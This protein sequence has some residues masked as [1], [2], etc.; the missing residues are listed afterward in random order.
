MKRIWKAELLLLMVTMIWGGTF[1]I[2]KSVLEDTPPFL[3][4]VYR[5]GIA[6][7]ISAIIWRKFLKGFAKVDIVQGTILGLLYGIGFLLQAFGLTLTSASKSGFVTG[8][9]VIFVPFAYW[10]LERKKIS[11]WHI[12][13]VIIVLLG[14]WIFTNPQMDNI[15]YGDVLTLISAMFWA[16]YIPYLDKI[17]TDTGDANAKSARLIMMQFLVTGVIG[18]FAHLLFENG[19]FKS[20]FSLDLVGAL[21]YTAVFATVIATGIQTRYQHYTTP[22]KAALIFSL[23][24]VFAAILAV[25]FIDDPVGARELWGGGIVIAGVLIAELG[26]TIFKNTALKTT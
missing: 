24:P 9:T 19:T 8:S 10:I 4:V 14:L 15:N 26:G 25:I 7:L 17:M 22:V 11:P 20:P 13:G 18:V 5:F 6:L 12:A 3:F 1:P 16:F 21:F 23:E 2:I